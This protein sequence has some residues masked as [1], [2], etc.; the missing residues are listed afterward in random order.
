MNNE[1]KKESEDSKDYNNL[2]GKKM[3]KRSKIVYIIIN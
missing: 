1:N 2:G 3:D